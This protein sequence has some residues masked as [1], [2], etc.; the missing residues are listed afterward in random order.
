MLMKAEQ[1]ILLLVD[2]QEKLMPSISH[3]GEVIHQCLTLA[4]M[5]GLLE[6]PVVGTEQLPEKLGPNV[7]EVRELCNQTFSK[8]HFDACP[9]GLVDVLPEGRQ[10]IVIGGCETH[11][12]MMQTALSLLDA[13]YKVWV[14]ADATGSRNEFDRDVALDRLHQ[15]G[16]KVV[17]TEMVAFEWLRHCRHPRFRD[18]QH[19]IK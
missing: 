18:I 2:L 4:T 19:L 5:A 11:V 6:V 13:G 14:V 12:C 1:S 9:D 16:A 17:T 3:G 10:H 7:A 8:Y 15:S